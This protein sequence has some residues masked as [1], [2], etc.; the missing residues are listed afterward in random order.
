M[1]LKATVL[2]DHPQTA[3]A[4]QISQK[5]ATSTRSL[6]VTGFATPGGVDTI[7]SAVRT[8]PKSLE[9]LVIGAATYP[10]FEA[11]E[12]L[13]AM[14]VPETRFRVHLGHTRESGTPRNP[15]IRFHPMLHSKIYY[16]EHPGGMASAFVGSHNLT[17]FALSG[18][19]G[20]ASILLEGPA[21]DPEFDRIRRHI[22]AAEKQ[23]VPFR[24]D[25]KE[26]FAWWTREFIDGMKAEMKLPS[27]WTTVRTILVFA[28]ATKSARPKTGD[29]L[30]FEIPGGIEQITNLKTETHLFLFEKLPADPWEALASAMQAEARYTC[31][32]LGVDNE[33]GNLEVVAQWRIEGTRPPVLL[34]EPSGIVRTATAPGRQQVRAKVK[35]PEVTAYEYFFDT[36]KSGWEPVFSKDEALRPSGIASGGL[37]LQEALGERRPQ[38]G[39]QAVQGLVPRSTEAKVNDQAALKL[40][41]PESGAF[42]LVSLRR[43]KKG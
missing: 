32:T 18:L 6:I 19:N 27:E 28:Q 1:P 29:Q 3:I 22:A 24:R 31:D 38:D 36:G 26:A 17:S 21:N 30:Y 43:S 10:G 20:E 12:R 15:F 37:A 35:E 11:I 4:A 9:S 13:I 41:S 34:S 5:L 25:M 8:N 7:A 14:G 39:W 42:I 2:F 23:S 40:A 33:R 16:T